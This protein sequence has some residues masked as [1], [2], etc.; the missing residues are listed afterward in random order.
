MAVSVSL[1]SHFGGCN[2]CDADSDGTLIKCAG[3]NMWWCSDV[4]HRNDDDN[5]GDSFNYGMG[6]DGKTKAKCAGCFGECSEARIDAV[7]WQHIYSPF[8]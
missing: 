6:S 3:C 8:L 1:R 7:P 5:N 4:C 2:H